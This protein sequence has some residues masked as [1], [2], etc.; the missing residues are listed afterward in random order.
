VVNSNGVSVTP[1]PVC[2]AINS[3]DDNGDEPISDD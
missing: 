1:A 2:H 3:V